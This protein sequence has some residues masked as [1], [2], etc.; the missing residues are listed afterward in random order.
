MGEYAVKQ[1]DQD[2][3]QDEEKVLF[4]GYAVDCAEYRADRVCPSSSGNDELLLSTLNNHALVYTWREAYI[5]P[6]CRVR[7]R[8]FTVST[9]AVW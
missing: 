3:L 6:W 7:C 1:D 5:V 2:R 8:L 9:S 4:D